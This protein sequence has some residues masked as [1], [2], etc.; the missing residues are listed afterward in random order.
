M[1]QTTNIPET[2]KISG[3][4]SLVSSFAVVALP[5]LLVPVLIASGFAPHKAALM[6]MITGAFVATAGL[7][8]LAVK[9][10]SA[11]SSS[12][13]RVGI[14]MLA[15]SPAGLVFPDVGAQSTAVAGVLSGTVALAIGH[16]FASSHK[17]TLETGLGALAGALAIATSINSY[18]PDAYKKVQKPE[19][20]EKTSGIVIQGEQAQKCKEIGYDAQRN[21]LTIPQGCNLALAR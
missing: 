4:Q 6:Q 11:I 5:S 15:A 7:P 3:V 12:V 8:F 13:G 9:P 18:A 14:G 10:D 2:S 1:T 19:T 20:P 16:F 17:Q 21:T